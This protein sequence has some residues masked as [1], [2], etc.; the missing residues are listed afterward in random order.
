MGLSAGQ[1]CLSVGGCSVDRHKYGMSYGQGSAARY[2]AMF[3]GPKTLWDASRGDSCML[4]AEDST[5]PSYSANV[6]CRRV[7]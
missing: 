3:W 4:P 2:M 5:T 6:L 7:V 1:P